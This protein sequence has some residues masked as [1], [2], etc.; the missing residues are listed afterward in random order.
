MNLAAYMTPLE[1]AAVLGVTPGRA[2]HFTQENHP[3]FIPGVVHVG[4][5]SLIPRLAIEKLAK[6]PTKSG[7]P[8][9]FLPRKTSGKQSI[10]DIPAK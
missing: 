6:Q 10:S 5:Q 9:K 8:R 3:D 4:N 2:R 7:R 1:A